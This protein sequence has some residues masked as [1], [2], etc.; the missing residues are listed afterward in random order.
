M[1]KDKFVKTIVAI[2]EAVEVNGFEFGLFRIQIFLSVVNG[3]GLSMPGDHLHQMMIPT[4]KQASYKHLSDTL[5]NKNKQSKFVLIT[6]GTLKDISAT[7]TADKMDPMFFEY[8]M[9]IISA[10]LVRGKFFRN[11]IESVL[12]EGRYGRI[13]LQIMEV[14]VK[15]SSLH[16]LSHHGMPMVKLFGTYSWVPVQMWKHEC[17]LSEFFN[18]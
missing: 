8:A 16:M 13:C 11:P 4:E 6:N 17:A 10:A 9:S 18:E 14:F 7:T 1:I 3:V 5:Q 15:G 12:C 2:K